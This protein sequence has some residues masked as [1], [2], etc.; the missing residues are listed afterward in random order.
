MEK[1]FNVDGSCDPKLHYMVDLTDRLRQIKDMVDS[2]KYFT[3]NKARQYGKTTTLTAL[4]AYLRKD[5]NVI[6]LD[7]QTLSYADFEKEQSFVA[8]FAGAVLLCCESIVEPV[9]KKLEAFYNREVQD[10]TLSMLF[11]CL[12]KW[13]RT[14]E[15]ELVLIIDEVDTASNN[16][17]FLDF[18]SQLRAYYLTRRQIPTF[19]S[20]I[21]AG[22]YDIRNLRQKIR[23]EDAHKL[24]SPWNI[25][26]KFRVNMSFTAEDIAG[27]LQE[28]EADWQ[29]GMDVER[30]SRLLYDYTEGYPYLVS[31]ICK[32][33]DEEIAGS[34]RF[35]DK[36]YA[37]TREGILEAVKLLLNDTS[38]LIE[39]LVGKLNEYPEL[40]R[41]I[42]T[43]LFEGQSI[44]YNPDEP[45]F[46]MALMFGFAKVENGS[47]RIANRIFETRLYNMFLSSP[48]DQEIALYKEGS[49]QKNQFIK[50]GQLDMKHL[51]EKF[52]EYFNDI[53]GDR[54]QRFLE[55]D[56]RRYFMLFLKPIINGTGNY[57]IEAR[58]R[59][60]ERTDIIIDYLGEQYIIEM[61][62]W[63]GDTYHTRGEQQL[64][65]YLDYYHLKKGYMLSFNFN[66]KKNPGVKEIVLGD[67]ILIEAVV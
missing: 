18:L 59:N 46:A 23:P 1:Y 29:A 63:H 53:Y 7:F 42:Y 62:I 44:T 20:V 34:D 39:S 45:S 5:Y 32:L 14:S 24:N 67:K 10:A 60:Y 54:E 19:R 38:P 41:V 30:I 12:L 65:D 51:L 58:T 9:R 33:V 13:C 52:V 57:Y 64:S 17:V 43:L 28:Y 48:D 11:H 56:G 22:V 3:V 61:K 26:A 49:R 15:K 2:G 36:S 6:H 40:K 47:L 21:L 27:M 55:E 50:N 25:A 4:A 31:A 66:K 8:A 37:W 35:P 16:Q